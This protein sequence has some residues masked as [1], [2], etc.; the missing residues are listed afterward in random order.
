[1]NRKNNII[2]RFN[3]LVP[4]GNYNRLGTTFET[5]KLK[6]FFDTGTG[7]VFECSEDEYSILSH[8]LS[9]M[10]FYLRMIRIRQKVIFAIYMRVFWIVLKKSMF[11]KLQSMLSLRQCLKKN[12]LIL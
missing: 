12:L 7:K 6:Y 2:N 5:E 10:S 4:D 11:Y 9:A 3:D 1:M 8:L